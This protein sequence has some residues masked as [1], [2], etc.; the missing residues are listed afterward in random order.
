M[1]NPIDEFARPTSAQWTAYQDALIASPGYSSSR[2][3]YFTALGL[4][5]KVGRMMYGFIHWNINA[6]R[7]DR[8]AFSDALGD[9]FRYLAIISKELDV[10]FSELDAAPPMVDV[11]DTTGLVLCMGAAAGLVA[12][13]LLNYSGFDDAPT[14]AIPGII[15]HLRQLFTCVCLLAAEVGLGAPGVMD[16]NRAKLSSVPTV[17]G[18][19]KH[20]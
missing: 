20:T 15:E 5:G 14:K 17:G 1:N 18:P 19:S 2:D 4:S 8:V 13:S 6:H 7:A 9:V 10:D 3:A 11:T 12:D 16:E